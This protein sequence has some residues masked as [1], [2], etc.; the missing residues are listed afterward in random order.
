MVMDPALFA[1]VPFGSRTAL[2][3]FA[4]SLEL[5]NRAL[6]DQIFALTGTA[7]ALR[8]VGTP[9]GFDWLLSIQKTMESASIALGLGSPP[10]LSSF[11]LREEEDHASFF[12]SLAQEY[13][14]LRR[15]AGLP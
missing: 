14:V 3:D 8:P 6:A 9:A 4:G 1:S 11:D 13:G 15:A 7:I 2:Q 12:F 5:L 10:D